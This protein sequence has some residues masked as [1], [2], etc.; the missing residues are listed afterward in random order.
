M[1]QRNVAGVA[2]KVPLTPAK[3]RKRAS[4]YQQ[5]LGWLLCAPIL[6][7]AVLSLLLV[8]FVRM[9]PYVLAFDKADKLP[10]DARP[11]R[12][13]DTSVQSATLTDREDSLPT[14]IDHI[15]RTDGVDSF[16]NSITT[17]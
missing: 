7:I 13:S 17:A 4:S 10:V 5:G 6:L 2:P 9:H 8:S 1:Q 15:V 12:K 16:N 11:E 14:L 3:R